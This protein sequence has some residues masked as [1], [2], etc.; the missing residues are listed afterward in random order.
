MARQS[1]KKSPAKAASKS[2]PKVLRLAFI[3]AGGIAQNQHMPRFAEMADV[4][5]V[6]ASDPNQDAL[7]A[8][9][10]KFGIEKHYSD[11]KQMLKQ[12]ELDAVSV[13]TPNFLHA[14]A[15]IDALNAGCHVLVEKPLAMNPAEGRKM[16]DAAKKN[17][18]ALVIGFQYRFHPATQALKRA[19][20]DGAF[21]EIYFVKCQALRRRGIPNW[22][23]FGRKDMQGGG[24][25]IDIGVHIMEMAH[26]VMGCPAPVAASGSVFT[27]IGNQPCNVACQWPDWDYKT[28][29]VEDLAIGQIRFETGAIMQV[30]VAFA[31]H[32]EKNIW[33]WKLMGQKGGCQWDPP[34]I[35]HDTYGSMTNSELG[36]FGANNQFDRKMRGFV[37]TALYG[38][39]SESPAEHGQMVQ[40]MIDGIYRSAETGREVTIK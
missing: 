32:I 2:T 25:M 30:E 16:L 21:G 38:K 10:T 31:A 12:E 35:F 18:K 33:N 22:G 20:D 24:A 11:W 40:K 26:Y 29:T 5:L 3:G 37:E 6:A 34:A 17:D 13:C 23:V 39:P 9:A 27:N 28:Y 36:H 4:E 14:P 7:N 1:T 15:A 8:V 19:A